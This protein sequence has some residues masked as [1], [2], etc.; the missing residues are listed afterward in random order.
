MESEE[1]RDKWLDELRIFYLEHKEEFKVNK[2]FVS[3]NQ[4]VKNG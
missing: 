1:E 4:E 2:E 3:V